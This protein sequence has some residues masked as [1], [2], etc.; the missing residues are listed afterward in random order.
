ML[1]LVPAKYGMPRLDSVP[2]S[3]S[4]SANPHRNAGAREGAKFDKHLRSRV[5]NIAPRIF[6]AFSSFAKQS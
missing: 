5:V 6:L 4:P 1:G 3:A 2:S